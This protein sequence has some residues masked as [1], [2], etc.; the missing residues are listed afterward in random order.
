MSHINSPQL[1]PAKIF[2][3]DPGR[4]TKMTH[5]SQWNSCPMV[6]LMASRHSKMQV[7]GTMLS[8]S[9]GIFGTTVYQNVLTLGR[10]IKMAGSNHSVI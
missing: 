3:P 6:S 1:N 4:W 9:E 8:Q 2:K 10:F 7:T 5:H